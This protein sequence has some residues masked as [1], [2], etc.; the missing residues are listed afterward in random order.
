[1]EK[2]IKN[3]YIHTILTKNEENHREKKRDTILK[4]SG[5]IFVYKKYF[6]K[7]ILNCHFRNDKINTLLLVIAS[8]I[9]ISF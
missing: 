7:D 1:M 8:K 6:P 2:K 9:F 3:K 4:T 5:I